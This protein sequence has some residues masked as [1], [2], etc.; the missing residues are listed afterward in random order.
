MQ[1]GLTPTEELELIDSHEALMK[2]NKK[3]E[4]KVKR[5]EDDESQ[6]YKVKYIKLLEKLT[7]PKEPK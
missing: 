6:D 1:N 3:L 7:Q 2:K 5:L 4:A